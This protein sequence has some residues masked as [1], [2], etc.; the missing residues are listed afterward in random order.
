MCTAISLQGKTHF[1][2]RNLDLEYSYPQQIAVTPHNFPFHFRC[3][4]KL[5]HHHAM[6][7]MATMAE[8]YPL[9]FEATNDVGLSMA[10]LSFP[11][12]S[13]Y[14]H[15]L[16]GKDN[17]APYELIPWVLG[18]CQNTFQAKQLLQNTSV[19]ALPF[20]RAYGLT[21]MH[22]IIADCEKTIVAE[23]LDEGLQVTDNPANI[24]TNSPQLG[25][26]LTHLSDYMHLQTGQSE[27]H[28]GIPSSRAYSNAMGAMGL[29]GDFSSASRFVKAAFV[30]AN[31]PKEST[32]V[33]QFFHL[34]NAV[35]MPLGSVHIRDKEY[36]ITRYSSCCDTKQG[37]Y[38]YTTYHNSRIRG[39]SMDRCKLDGNTVETFDPL[40][41]QDIFYQ[42]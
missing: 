16:F 1:F 33:S 11:H 34:L 25:Y 30:T 37:I 2:G 13:V 42:N 23:P 15:K 9:Y 6:I 31:T 27:D 5:E 40:E 14:Q 32:D 28:W 24:L 41:K 12:Y 3:G 26:H 7:G 36:E 21:P 39:V 8:G 38:Y 18:Q 19:W 22:W 20:S 10:G 29:P 4:I 35:A 17:I